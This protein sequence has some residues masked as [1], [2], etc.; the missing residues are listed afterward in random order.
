LFV[1]V[2]VAFKKKEETTMAKAI[3]NKLCITRHGVIMRTESKKKE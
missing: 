3:G 1:V 2:A